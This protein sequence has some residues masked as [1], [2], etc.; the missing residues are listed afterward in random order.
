MDGIEG[1]AGPGNPSDIH[2][3]MISAY[4]TVDIAVEAMKLGGRTSSRSPSPRRDRELVA[5]VIDR[6]GWMRRRPPIM[7]L[8]SSCPSE[9]S[10][11]GF[12]MRRRTR[13]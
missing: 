9:A 5:K 13:P 4:G 1:F 2:V 10:G 7:R 8:I 11:S 3:I 12:S 6:T